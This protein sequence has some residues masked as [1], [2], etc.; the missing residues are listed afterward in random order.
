M[1]LMEAE[2]DKI[3][4]ELPTYWKELGEKKYAED[5]YRYLMKH[6]ELL[7]SDEA[8]KIYEYLGN[9]VVQIWCRE[10]KT[11]DEVW[12]RSFID[13]MFK[14]QIQRTPGYAERGKEYA[15]FLMKQIGI[16]PSN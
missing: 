6:S 8:K 2:I 10:T 16:Y 1:K 13:M 15:E 11:Q 5:A 3:L 7:V 4:E 9:R 12:M 14:G